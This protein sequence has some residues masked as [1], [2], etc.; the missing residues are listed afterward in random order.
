M[1]L[2]ALKAL[3]VTWPKLLTRRWMNTL[4]MDT[5]ACW[6]MAGMPSF[7]QMRNFSVSNT[8]SR[9]PNRKMG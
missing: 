4:P 9:R 7:R 2:P 3:I 6:I 1:R 5:T 8:N